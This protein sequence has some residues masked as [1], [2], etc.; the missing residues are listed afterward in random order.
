MWLTVICSLQNCISGLGDRLRQGAIVKAGQAGIYA[1][2]IRGA[3][4]DL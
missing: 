2:G 3:C 1:F 4:P